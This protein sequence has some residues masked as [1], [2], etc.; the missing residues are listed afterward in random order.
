MRSLKQLSTLLITFGILLFVLFIGVT[1]LH[2][3]VPCEEGGYIPNNG[4]CECGGDPDCNVVGSVCPADLCSGGAPP[5]ECCVP[6]SNASAC[7]GLPNWTYLHDAVCRV[8]HP[9]L[10]DPSC[11]YRWESQQCPVTDSCMGQTGLRPGK[12]TSDG[13]A[14]GT[15]IYKTCCNSSGQAVTCFGGQ[16]T[17]ICTPNQTVWGTGQSSDCA[18]SG[19][20]SSTPP[21]NPTAT[22]IPQGCEGSNWGGPC[23]NW[24]GNASGCW[25]NG[26]FNGLPSCGYCADTGVCACGGA[27]PPNGTPIPTQPPAAACSGTC[28]KSNPYDPDDVW[29]GGPYQISQCDSVYRPGHYQWWH[30]GTSGAGGNAGDE[31]CEERYGTGYD[32]RDA[33]CGPMWPAPTPVTLSASPLCTNT[34]S[35]WSWTGG[36]G[37][38]DIQRQNSA[39][40]TA[41]NWASTVSGSS[42]TSSF[43]TGYATG[44]YGIRVSSHMSIPSWSSWVNIGRDVTAPSTPGGLNLVCNTNG[45]VSASW[46]PATDTG[47]G[48]LHNYPYWARLSTDPNF[49]S[50]SVI[51]SNDT[52]PDGWTSGITKS[53]PASAFGP[54]ITVYGRVRSRDSFDT[55][56]AWATNDSCVFPTAIPS[57]TPGTPVVNAGP[58][59]TSGNG[60]WTWSAVSPPAASY[61]LQRQGSGWDWTS[62]QTA[63]SFTSNFNSGFSTGSYGVRVAG[64]NVSGQ[65]GNWSNWANISRDISAPSVPITPN[66]TYATGECSFSWTAS[67][68]AGCG[69]CA[70]NK[71]CTY[72]LQGNWTGGGAGSAINN[73]AW[74]PP[75]TVSPSY[76]VSCTG[77]SGKTFSLK[78]LEAKDSLDNISSPDNYTAG[79][80]VC[81]AAP[82]TPPSSSSSSS[83]PP[84][85]ECTVGDQ[86]PQAGCFKNIPPLSASYGGGA[87]QI[88]FG[89]DNENGFGSPWSCNSG[90]LS[91]NPSTFSSCSVRPPTLAGVTEY[92]SVDLSRRCVPLRSSSCRSPARGIPLRR[93]AAAR[94]AGQAEIPLDDKGSLPGG[95]AQGWTIVRPTTLA[96]ANGHRRPVNEFTV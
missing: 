54:G 24:N 32:K 14:V 21:G 41:W 65:N 43:T 19:S 27:C 29:H 84:G 68:D 91:P 94:I 87:D 16:N 75:N 50:S 51:Y 12:C 3:F 53:T 5:N 62:N 72:W 28:L 15:S 45:S 77:N 82:T 69:A 81:P 47:C 33:C 60:T 85:G 20:S 40:A 66:G 7:S 42:Y 61:D 48:G 46:S 6:G 73:G 18:G 22:P 11:T 95:P 63:I 86:N 52:W 76:T 25:S 8:Y 1:Q 37:G 55:Q 31:N 17:G 39:G 88:Q 30:G 64:K 78:V 59:C 57:P 92:R 9:G 36:A 49:G 10:F 90:W 4:V 58:A 67:L 26:Q 70:V 38:Y 93:L 35:T 13:C 2:A 80:C 83:S 89:V 56:S 34:N 74:T 23:S 96:G 71:A 79:T 44:N